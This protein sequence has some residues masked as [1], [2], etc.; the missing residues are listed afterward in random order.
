MLFIVR[1]WCIKLSIIESNIKVIKN[2]QVI[3]NAKWH[4]GSSIK[5]FVT[6]VGSLLYQTR[7]KVILLIK[8]HSFFCAKTCM[9][10]LGTR[11]SFGYEP[12][13]ISFQERNEFEAAVA[14]VESSGIEL[15]PHDENSETIIRIAPT[16]LGL[17]FLA[18]VYLEESKYGK[19]APVEILKVCD[20]SIYCYCRR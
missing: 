19:G 12:K 1:M 15:P 11:I 18:V 9:H 16:A 5:S 7:F 17:P 4:I 3:G 13:K 20:V 2:H 8:L 6:S 14:A 10:S